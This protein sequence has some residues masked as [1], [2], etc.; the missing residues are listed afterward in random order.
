MKLLSTLLILAAMTVP[1]LA[2][3]SPAQACANKLDAKA[4]LIFA[5]ALP[6]I[7]PGSD[8]KTIITDITKSLVGQGQ[9]PRADARGAAMSA[10]ECLKLTQ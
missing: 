2:S 7:K 9:I 10:G 3:D 1:A 8:L 4:K 5:N 6:Q